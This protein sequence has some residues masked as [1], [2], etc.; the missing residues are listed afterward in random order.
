MSRKLVQVELDSTG[1]EDLELIRRDLGLKN[2]SEVLRH[3]I[4]NRAKEI[5][6]RR[7]LQNVTPVTAGEVKG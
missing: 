7:Q 1:I 3:L 4:R 2:Y 5:R 6:E